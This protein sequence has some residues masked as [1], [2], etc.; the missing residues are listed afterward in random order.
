MKRMFSKTGNEE[1]KE[2]ISEKNGKLKLW[3]LAV[4][5]G[6]AVGVGV[7]IAL[8]MSS[9]VSGT[10]GPKPPSVL[11]T[12]ACPDKVKYVHY[13]K[14]KTGDIVYLIPDPSLNR[15]VI[16]HEPCVPYAT[17]TRPSDEKLQGVIQM[18]W[19]VE[20][21]DPVFNVKVVFWKV[22][23]PKLEFIGWADE[24]LLVRR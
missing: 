8:L 18:D 14:F 1:K 5:L 7:I 24:K 16:Y 3:H 12:T 21:Y 6:V 11:P 2:V 4:I 17:T 22:Y 15:Y 13:G 23:I 9:N 10:I 20:F 19:G